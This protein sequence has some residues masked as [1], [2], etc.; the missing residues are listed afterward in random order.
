MNS[1]IASAVFPSNAAA[2]KAARHTEDSDG[3][4]MNYSLPAYEIEDVERA[5]AFN[6][7]Q[8]ETFDITS[9]RMEPDLGER[10]E[11]LDFAGVN[12]YPHNQ[13]VMDK[14]DGYAGGVP[15]GHH[16]FR[17]LADMLADFHRR[18]E[19][20]IVI[21]E[22]GAEGSGR[23]PWFHY[24]CQEMEAAMQAGV[25]VEGV[26]VYPVVNYPGWDDE[27][28]C[29]TGLFGPPG[30]DNAR[31]VYQPLADELQRWKQRLRE[32]VRCSIRTRAK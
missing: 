20:S 24:V 15:I 2:A 6:R 26:C 9:G 18:Y 1:R 8:F 27:R 32:D 23:A 12:F 25:P 4:K 28:H 31:A 17:P 10:P 5:A 14:A 16:A 11:L 3:V 29:A 21:A 13:W 22:T 7:A 19:R 30:A